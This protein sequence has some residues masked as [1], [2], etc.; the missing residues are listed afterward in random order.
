MWYNNDV[1][2]FVATSIMQWLISKLGPKYILDKTIDGATPL[3]MAAALGHS[4]ILRFFL[5][6]LED[7]NDIDVLDHIHATPAHDAAEYGQTEAMILL[8]KHGANTNI[9]DTVGH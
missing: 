6:T 1:F 7:E 4:D 3:H 5:D 9:K 2:Q 8:L